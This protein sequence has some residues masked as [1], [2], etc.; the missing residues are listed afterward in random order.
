MPGTKPFPDSRII[1]TDPH[2][3]NRSVQPPKDPV[4]LNDF[5]L[6]DTSNTKP[7]KSPLTSSTHSKVFKQTGGEVR[8]NFH[9]W[10][11]HTESVG[12]G[13]YR[14]VS[15]GI[16]PRIKGDQRRYESML[17]QVQR[18]VDW[19]NAKVS[20]ELTEEF[21]RD[22]SF[23]DSSGIGKGEKVDKATI[24][25]IEPEPLKPAEV[26][27]GMVTRAMDLVSEAKTP[28]EQNS[29]LIT[30]VVMHTLAS[31]GTGGEALRKSLK[32]AEKAYLSE[33]NHSGIRRRAAGVMLLAVMSG[34]IVSC[35]PD[36]S[37]PSVPP[38]TPTSGESSEATTNATVGPP[39]VEAEPSREPTMPST[40]VESS[41]Q[42]SAPSYDQVWGDLVEGL[43]PRQL[44][45]FSMKDVG[46]IISGASGG[47]TEV[48]RELFND[49]VNLINATTG[50]DADGN[51]VDPDSPLLDLGPAYPAALYRFDFQPLPVDPERPSVFDPQMVIRIGPAN[52]EETPGLQEGDFILWSN[53]DEIAP[54]DGGVRDNLLFITRGEGGG[55][56]EFGDMGG[57]NPGQTF[58]RIGPDNH[59]TQF[60]TKDLQWQD[61]NGG[62]PESIPTEVP[63]EP[64]PEPTA[65]PTAEPSPEPTAEPTAEPSPEP[66]ATPER[67]SGEALMAEVEANVTVEC[68]Y[69]NKPVEKIWGTD[70]PVF[71]MTN[72]EMRQIAEDPNLCFLE[73]DGVANPNRMELNP[74]NPAYRTLLALAT[75][76][77]LVVAEDNDKWGEEAAKLRKYKGMSAEEIVAQYVED[78]YQ[79]IIPTFA[80]DELNRFVLSSIEAPN[81]RHIIL[82]QTHASAEFT[83][84]LLNPVMVDGVF[85][86]IGSA[87]G[88][89]LTEDSLVWVQETWD[90]SVAKTSAGFVT[91]EAMSN[92]A[93]RLVIVARTPMIGTPLSQIWPNM[94]TEQDVIRAAVKRTRLFL[95]EG[96]YRLP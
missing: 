25:P 11:I 70:T 61:I 5:L 38:Q 33:G 10:G 95:V 44:E 7:T 42:E 85:Y 47:D 79:A 31:S 63:T 82:E 39:Q 90:S 9:D 50:L 48:A 54:V 21:F 62:S 94:L 92:W 27:R 32:E 74:D 88:V 18:R 19:H 15:G 51:P 84:E 66:T 49:T 24:S 77:Q 13:F 55:R 28:K 4:P 56:V 53:G 71:T 65:E 16:E 89:R 40:T 69:V 96:D 43:T 87:S 76:T 35:A 29:L 59:V 67:L 78:G 57:D 23:V 93:M 60:V 41:Q 64:T 37:Q 46:S 22:T 20:R 34:V 68:V 17:K 8:R 2:I 58:V 3:S 75:I 73:E 14:V 45:I 91:S 81:M 26:Y 30:F 1:F 36:M 6:E 12:N 72:N 80:Q 52:G 86:G 83:D